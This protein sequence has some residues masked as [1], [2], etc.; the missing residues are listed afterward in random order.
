MFCIEY[1][2]KVIIFLCCYEL[3][4]HH[5]K[6]LH[7]LQPTVTLSHSLR[8][9]MIC[10]CFCQRKQNYCT[11]KGPGLGFKLRISILWDNN[12][13]YLNPGKVLNNKIILQPAKNDFFGHLGEVET[14]CEHNTYMTC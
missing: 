8:A 1:R 7:L 5:H 2:A 11:K 6:Q 3:H 12:A 4:Y 10:T 13:N 9:E 14:S